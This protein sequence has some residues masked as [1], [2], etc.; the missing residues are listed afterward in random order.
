MSKN[1]NILILAATTTALCGV[2]A[3]YWRWPKAVSGEQIDQSITHIK[4]SLCADP[5]YML[6]QRFVTHLMKPSRLDQC[7]HDKHSQCLKISVRK[8]SCSVS[9]RW[10]YRLDRVFLRL[11]RFLRPSRRLYHR[12]RIDE[13]VKVIILEPS[14]DELQAL[15]AQIA[16]VDLPRGVRIECSPYFPFRHSGPPAKAKQLVDTE[17]VY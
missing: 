16:L 8:A 17:I 15:K 6:T 10:G 2:C 1:K 9:S 5:N 14:P 3:A 12:T 7:L 11:P 13:W 4:A